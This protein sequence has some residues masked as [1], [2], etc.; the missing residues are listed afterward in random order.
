[1]KTHSDWSPSIRYRAIYGRLFDD[2]EP[3]KEHLLALPW[4][5]KRSARHEYFMSDHKL[6]YSYDKQREGAAP[7]PLY[8]SKPMTEDVQRIMNGLNYLLESN[9][10]ACFLNKYDDHL[11]HLGW[12]ADDFDG[13]D[14]SQPIAVVSFGAER[15]IWLKDQR[16]FSCE[17]CNGSGEIPVG[18]GLTC[19]V[20]EGSGFTKAPPNGKQ[21]MDQRVL[22]EEGSLFVMPVGYQS[23]HFHRIPKHDRPCGWRISLTFRSFLP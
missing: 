2:V 13:M 7:V 4:E 5:T 21:P 10:N 19:G 8:S 17:T 11:Q 18:F 20:C 23:T 9:F 16:G 3:I 1:M 15:E 22:L 6:S 14:Q 12:H